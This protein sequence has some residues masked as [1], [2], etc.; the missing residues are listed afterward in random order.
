[1]GNVKGL[2]ALW[3]AQ[4]LFECDHSRNPIRGRRSACPAVDTVV[5]AV[6]GNNFDPWKVKQPLCDESLNLP[7]GFLWNR[8]GI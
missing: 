5:T 2:P 4:F 1:M 8:P 7:V 6:V 3:I